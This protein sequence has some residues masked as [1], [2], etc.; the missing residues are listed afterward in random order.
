MNF[1]IRSE[2]NWLTYVTKQYKVIVLPEAQE[3][4]RS[5][6]LY[7]ANDLHAIDAAQ[8]LNDKFH[9]SVSS[10]SEMPERFQVVE[11]EPWH[12]VNVRRMIVDSYYVYY[13][14]LKSEPKVEIL[15]VVYIGRDQREHMKRSIKY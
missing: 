2:R 10:L 8:E 13:W 7:I 14:I 9:Q 11:D 5:I 12:S 15:S 6:V 1:S 4:I 3:D